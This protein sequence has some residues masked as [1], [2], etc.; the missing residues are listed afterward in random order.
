MQVMYGARAHK[1]RNFCS[2]CDQPWG[3]GSFHFLKLCIVR[4]Q[5]MCR[6]CLSSSG[7]NCSDCLL[8]LNDDLRVA[9][10]RRLTWANSSDPKTLSATDVLHVTHELARLMTIKLPADERQNQNDVGANNVVARLEVQDVFK[11][12]AER[13]REKAQQYPNEERSLEGAA[14]FDR[15]PPTVDEIPHPPPWYFEDI[16]TCFVVKDQGGQALAFVYY[17]KGLGRRSA[18]NPVTK[19]E[20]R[21]IAAN[22]VKLPELLYR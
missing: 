4:T 11:E 14:T 20:A 9:F 17:D 16:G 15:V 3:A 5:S 7:Q 12:K 22:I 10:W 19:D 6:T 18:A 2:M 1:I 13:R 8:Q 21:R